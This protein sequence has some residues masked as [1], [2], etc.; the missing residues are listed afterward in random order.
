[1]INKEHLQKLLPLIGPIAL[2]LLWS[3]MLEAKWVK[4]ILLPPPGATL[5]YM[6]NS[7][8]SGAIFVDLFATITN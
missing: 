2:L 1:M 8:M 7:F 4:P 3:L 6:A 5:A